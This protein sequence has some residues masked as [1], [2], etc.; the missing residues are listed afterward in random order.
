MK[1]NPCSKCQKKV[2]AQ[3]IQNDQPW[4]DQCEDPNEEW[5]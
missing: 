2:I 4:M 3:Q 1:K 5:D